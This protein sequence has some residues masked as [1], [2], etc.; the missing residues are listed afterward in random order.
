MRKRKSLTTLKNKADK[1]FREYIK[2]RDHKC[3]WCGATEEKVKLDVHH[4]ISRDVHQVRFDPDNGI[5][6]C[7]GCHLGHAGAHKRPLEFADFVYE[8]LGDERY[9]GLIKRGHQ[10]ITPKKRDFYIDWIDRLQGEIDNIKHL[11]Q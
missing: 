1:L 4:I 2:L 9:W 8:R 3:Q 7:A 10:E 6:L 11:E 5:L